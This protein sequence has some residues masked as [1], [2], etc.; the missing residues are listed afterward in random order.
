MNL[1]GSIESAEQEFQQ[2]L[3]DFFINLYRANENKSLSSHDIDHHRRVWNYAKELLLMLPDKSP[4]NITQLPSKLIIACYLHDI[5]MSVETGI[6]HGKHSRD[7]CTR[8]FNRNHIN[9]NDYIDVLDAIENHDNKDYSPDTYTS[10]LLTILSMA[11]D[12]DAFGF[13][14]IYRY[15]EIYLARGIRY[16]ELGSLIKENASKRYNN[17]VNNTGNKQ[18]FVQVHKRRYQILDN[19]FNSYN[20]QITLYS[21]GSK[22][23]SGYCGIIELISQI[24]KGNISFQ[25]LCVDTLNK[26][27]DPI[28]TWYIEGLSSEL[29]SK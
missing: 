6:I 13:V 12:L 15:A 1:T 16:N 7:I 14:G 11:D 4:A 27:S 21:F 18:S 22:N 3:E 23:P 26:S 8:F 24:N 10:E 20:D 2:I 5:G 29:S 28:I 9:P 17:F 25:D 19:F